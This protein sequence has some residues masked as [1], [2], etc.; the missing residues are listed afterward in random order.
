MHVSKLEQLKKWLDDNKIM[1][2]PTSAAYQ[3]L[4]VKVGNDWLSIY[5][6]DEMQEHY[7]VDFRLDGLIRRFIRSQKGNL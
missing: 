2:R 6:R 5:R 4:Q 3:V 7:S 1:H